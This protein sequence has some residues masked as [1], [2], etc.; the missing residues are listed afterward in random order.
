MDTT[1]KHFLFSVSIENT[2]GYVKTE[3]FLHSAKSIAE[4][5]YLIE[6]YR[7]KYH[8]LHTAILYAT[9]LSDEEY[10]EY[11]DSLAG[12]EMDLKEAR[13]YDKKNKISH[14]D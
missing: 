3:T 2:R 8:L 11:G 10:A 12:W 1:E 9:I 6:I 14:E 7:L 13:E 5:A 4:I